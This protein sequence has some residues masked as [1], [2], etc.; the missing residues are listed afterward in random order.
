M[1]IKC[2]VYL[3][4][5]TVEAWIVDP[6]LEQIEVVTTT[7]TTVYTRQQQLLSQVLLGFS[8]IVHVLFP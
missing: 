8:P 5:G 3:Q 6:E 7:T 2:Q 4:A 1:R